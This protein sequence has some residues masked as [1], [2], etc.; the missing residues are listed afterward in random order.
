MR[1]LCVLWCHGEPVAGAK[2]V[3][4][5]CLWRQAAQMCC[6]IPVAVHVVLVACVCTRVVTADSHRAGRAAR[7]GS[8]LMLCAALRIVGAGQRIGDAGARSLALLLRMPYI[9]TH[10]D[11]SGVCLHWCKRR[12]HG[13]WMR[14]SRLVLVVVTCAG[15]GIGD[16]GMASVVDRLRTLPSLTHVDLSGERARACA[17]DERTALGCRS[18]EAW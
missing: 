18:G 12:A 10:L 2:N 16:A 5:E 17:T 15:N 13:T 14:R 11:L 7:I 1:S 6:A 8:D 9:L 3:D 4:S